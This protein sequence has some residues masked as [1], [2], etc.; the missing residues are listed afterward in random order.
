MTGYILLLAF[1]F[2]VGFSSYFSLKGQS[3][4]NTFLIITFLAIFLL[5]A[6]RASS[7]GRD[8]PGYKDMYLITKHVAWDNYDYVYFESG[9][10]LLM[11]I[12]TYLGMSFQMFLAVVSAIILIPIYIYFKKYSKNQFLSVLIYIGYLYFEF[13][14]TG[15]RQAI[16]TSVVLIGFMLYLRGGKFARLVLIGFILLASTFH[17]G[18]FVCLLFIPLSYIKSMTSYTFTVSIL[19]VVSFLLRSKIM[20]LVNDFFKE[21]KI[22]EQADVYIGLNF[23]FILALSVYFVFSYFARVK[24]K[25]KTEAVDLPTRADEIQIKW[26]LLSVMIMLVFGLDTSVR[27]YMF[28]SQVLMV[29]LPNSMDCWKKKDRMILNMGLIAFFVIFFF[30]NSLIPNNFDIVPYKFFWK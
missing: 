30:T 2:V 3:K 14:M 21:D 24:N 5:Y 20:V 16:A 13:N 8:L 19:T 28:Y 17:K 11:K 22:N 26:F 27:S 1:V 23:V 7:V 15:I 25:D 18:A 12:C 29:Q 6:L 9:Y 10:I 4:G